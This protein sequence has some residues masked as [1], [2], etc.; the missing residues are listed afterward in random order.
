MFCTFIHAAMQ[1]SVPTAP[2]PPPQIRPTPLTP[3]QQLAL[4]RGA[5]QRILTNSN[6][7]SQ[8]TRI[9]LL[10]RLAT[11]APPS[12]GIGDE[13]LQHMLKAYH[14]NQGHDLAITW[15][16]ALYKQHSNGNNSSG[17]LLEA[18]QEV[19]MQ[20][21]VCHGEGVKAASAAATASGVSKTKGNEST[22]EGQ[23][24]VKQEGQDSAMDV[25]SV[26]GKRPFGRLCCRLQSMD[27]HDRQLLTGIVHV[28]PV[29]S[30]RTAHKV[31]MAALGFMV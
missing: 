29:L 7:P 18:S 10:S 16:F 5:I 22:A 17:K 3:K 9:A 11:T 12:D 21:G 23:T 8:E 24:V 2:K 31:N 19:S 26:A 30:S 15:L 14:S 4:R 28:I 1:A 25:D 6:T 27:V 13:I 20:A